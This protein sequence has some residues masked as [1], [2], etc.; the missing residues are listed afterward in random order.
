MTKLQELKAAARE[1][2]DV[3]IRKWVKRG[4]GLDEIRKLLEG[5]EELVRKI[6]GVKPEDYR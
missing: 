3:M 4:I 6:R 5:G 2:R 1:E